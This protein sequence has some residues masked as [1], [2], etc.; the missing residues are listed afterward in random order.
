MKIA[1]I[2]INNG[3]TFII[4]E[5]GQNHNGSME[6]AK[7]LIDVAHI[8]GVDAVKFCK[9]S[10]KSIL[11]S[12]RFER[13][14]DNPN[15]FGKTYK[16]H[17]MALEL[18]IEQHQELAIY[19]KTK[20][21]VYFA[22]VCDLDMV[23]PMSEFMPC[24]KVASRDLTNLPLLLDMRATGKPILLSTGMSTIKEVRAV[25]NRLGSNLALL[26]C[27]SQ[28]PTTPENVKLAWIDVLRQSFSPLPIGWSDHTIGIS[29]P[30]VAIA[31]G[32][33]IVEKHITLD[34]TMKGTDH[35]G[36]LEPQGLLKLVR[37][38]REVELGMVSRPYFLP[39][40]EE[41]KEKLRVLE[42]RDLLGPLD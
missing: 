34:R 18:T 4:A 24:F 23:F 25:V 3:K 33:C 20:S 8:A 22:S 21:L 19:A 37:N 16:E 10:E 13:P 42:G 31:K 32:A 5:I 17:R 28:Y 11:S 1:N 9:R 29:I 26:I 7:K 14:Y 30:V 38:I 6:I 15:S 2:T 40:E 41:A 39:C 27:T 12:A 36:S 35:V